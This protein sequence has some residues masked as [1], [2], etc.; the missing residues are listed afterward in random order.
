[1]IELK[2]VIRVAEAAGFTVDRTARGHWRFRTPEGRVVA[3]DA[4]SPSDWRGTRNTIA[5][6]R[7]AGLR[8][9]RK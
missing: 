9:P 1:M 5:R 2:D 4:G 7:R 8:I 3:Y 6:L